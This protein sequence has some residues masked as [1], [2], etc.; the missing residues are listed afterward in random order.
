[1]FRTGNNFVCYLIFSPIRIRD[2]VSNTKT[3]G[4]GSNFINSDL[5]K[6]LFF[7]VCGGGDCW[8]GGELGPHLVVVYFQHDNLTTLVNFLDF[9]LLF[10]LM[11]YYLNINKK[12]SY[13]Q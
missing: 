5:Q 9:L 13:R 7:L 11:F 12:L 3:H 10:L 8:Q 4:S 1:M 6:G 2:R